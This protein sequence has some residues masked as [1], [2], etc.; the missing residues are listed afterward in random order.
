MSLTDKNFNTYEEF[1]EKRKRTENIL[2]YIDGI[3]YMSPSS[4]IE[5]QR[6]SSYL[7]GELYQ[8]LK[9]S[10]CEVFSAPTDVLFAGNAQNTN[11]HKRVVPDSFVTCQPENFT[12]NEYAGAPEFIIEILSRSNKSHDLVRKLNLYMEHGVK[13]YWIIDP[14]ENRILIYSHDENG[15]IQFD[16]VNKG[17]SAISRIFNHFQIETKNIFN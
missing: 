4:S 12:K 2:E 17:D 11:D 6:I 14:M 13:E 8:I 10:H 7:Q 9:S 1:E 15:E 5:H 16:L 3:I